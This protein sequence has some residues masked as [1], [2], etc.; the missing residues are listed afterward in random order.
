MPGTEVKSIYVFLLES[1]DDDG[2]GDEAWR[3]QVVIDRDRYVIYLRSVGPAARL[4][5]SK[6]D[7]EAR[8]VYL[9]HRPGRAPQVSGS[10]ISSNGIRRTPV[11]AGIPQVCADIP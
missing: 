8:A 4:P 6:P 9:V 5:R 1:R 10:T 2:D 11:S 3:T 7:S